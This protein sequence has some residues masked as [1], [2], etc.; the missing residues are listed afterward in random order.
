MPRRVRHASI[1][2]SVAQALATVVPMYSGCTLGGSRAYQV[3]D[4]ESDVEMYFYSLAE[5]P[6]LDCINDCMREL[7]AIHRRSPEFIWDRQPWGPH[8]FFEVDGL[9]FEVGYRNVYDIGS[10]LV[11]YLKG[12]V[13]PERDCHDLGLGYMPGSLAA[14]VR[15]EQVVDSRDGEITKLKQL[16]AMFPR[17][18]RLALKGE[19]LET[20]RSLLE[21][22]LRVVALRGDFL[23]YDAIAS[24]VVRAM[25]V[26]AF[27][28]SATHFPGDKWNEALLGRSEWRYA[29]EFL[30]LLRIHS[31]KPGLEP[32]QLN[33]KHSLLE[34]A[35]ML[36]EDEAS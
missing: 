13:Q 33:H 25:M 15:A 36:L 1:I 26:M 8:S 23:A 11:A 19:Y 34:R 30:A 9:Y 2:R 3:D 35:L 17:D 7:G 27:T 14:S 21:S 28:L 24:R 29:Q 6:S 4:D 22:K 31:L 5:P 16:V 32:A 18:L 20:A 10:R 12:S